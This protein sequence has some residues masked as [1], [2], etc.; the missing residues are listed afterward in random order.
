VAAIP[1]AQVVA[2]KAQVFAA[3]ALRARIEANP[4]HPRAEALRDRSASW[5]RK[6]GA[7]EVAV[8]PQEE[9]IFA[10]PLGGLA[11]GPLSDCQWAGEDVAVL[12][13]ALGLGERPTEWETVNATPLTAA[14]R[15]M[16]GDGEA[17]R[18][19]VCLRPVEELRDYFKRLSVVRWATHEVRLKR[20]GPADP[21]SLGVLGKVLRERLGNAGVT[22]SDADL[23]AGRAE[24]RRIGPNGL[25]GDS[26]IPGL[27]VVRQLAAEWI[28]GGR[29]PFWSDA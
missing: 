18:Q 24:I 6:V 21:R 29:S 15:F 14:L 23:A 25:T 19:Q 7:W 27:L 11:S 3:L 17:I 16:Q 4:D 10:A 1:K 28:V 26:P 2:A 20:G 12:A 5:L 9:Y 13:W 22:L 8:E